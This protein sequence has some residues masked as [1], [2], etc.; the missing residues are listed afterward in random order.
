MA[1]NS[2]ALIA[3]PACCASCARSSSSAALTWRCS[4]WISLAASARP[5]VGCIFSATVNMRVVELMT[6]VRSGLTMPLPTWRTVSSSSDETS[7]SIAPG[8]GFR[9]NTG[10]RPGWLL[11][12]CGQTST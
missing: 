12:G 2:T 9:L 11:A 1:P 4:V 6:S 8:A 7:R 3:V 10:R 5:S